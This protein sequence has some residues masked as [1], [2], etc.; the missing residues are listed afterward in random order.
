MI[1][2][3]HAGNPRL[4]GGAG[5][6]STIRVATGVTKRALSVNRLP[7]VVV[8][9]GVVVVVVVVQHFFFFICCNK[10]LIH[11][12]NKRASY[13]LTMDTYIHIQIGL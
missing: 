4:G 8:F 6:G 3:T 1:D 11:M 12:G 5:F 7:P 2:A 10:F 13:A 9:V